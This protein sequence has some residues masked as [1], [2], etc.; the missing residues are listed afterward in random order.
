MESD[1]LRKVIE[2]WNS[3]KSIKEIHEITNTPIQQL[4]DFLLP[5]GIQ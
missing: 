1:N 4:K 5:K 3:G 2:L